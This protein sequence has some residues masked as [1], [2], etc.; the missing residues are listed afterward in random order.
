M[1][2]VTVLGA[3]AFGTSLAIYSHSIG[4]AVKVWCFEKELPAI[5]KEKGENE[6]YLP[7][8]PVSPEIEFQPD[9]A[10]SL[11]GADIVLVV[12][13]SAHVRRV[14]EAAAPH[15]PK[16]ALIVAAAKGIEHGSLALMSQVLEETL[17][18]HKDHL[19]YLSGP[20]F[21]KDVAAGLPTDLACASANI[22]MAR[23][24]QDKLHSPN[25]RIYTSDDVIGVELGGALKNIIAV[26]CGA[27]DGLGLGLSARASLI[28]RGLAEISRLGVAL[29]A[30][31]ITFLGLAGVGD[32]I[33]TCTGD[34]S[35]NRT[36]GKNLATSGKTAAEIVNSQKSVAEGYV[37]VK[38]VYE[39]S[40]KLEVDMPISSAVYRV[41]YENSSL[42]SEASAL[43]ERAKK[44]EF[45]GLH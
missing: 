30:K 15:I 34:L 1:A 16:E 19:A 7:G 13:P 26:A 28:T 21:A 39:L 17:S 35:R 14:S 41:C 40:R 23:Q 38:P 42:K 12:C 36:L 44:D 31:P 4:H 33:L 8:L 20:S 25:L 24:V 37:T 22:E 5:V 10:K 3:G 32:L 11:A 9:M 18:D 6:I 45:E 27:S 2:N 29:G 43:M